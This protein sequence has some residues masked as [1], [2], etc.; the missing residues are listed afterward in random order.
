MNLADPKN[1]ERIGVILLAVILFLSGFILIKDN[2]K[3]VEFKENVSQ[4]Q[5]AQIVSQNVSQTGAEAQKTKININKA[6]IEE[7]DTLPG[8]GEKTAAKI[9]D[10]RDQH[11]GFKSIEEI[12][13]VNGIG[14]AK[15]DGIKDLISI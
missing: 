9:I 2:P 12:K 8:I 6:S 1:R 15:Y 11:K 7:L 3:T 14:D 4:E 13:E 5:T 10:Y